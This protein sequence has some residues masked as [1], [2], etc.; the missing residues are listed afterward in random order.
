MPKV[1]I[2]SGKPNHPGGYNQGRKLGKQR[3]HEHQ[4]YKIPKQNGQI[5]ELCH[6][7]NC[8]RRNLL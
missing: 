6:V 4:L 7:P 3:N 5:V 8:K 2:R 1:R